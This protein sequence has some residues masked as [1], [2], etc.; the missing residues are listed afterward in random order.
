[1]KATL[2]HLQ[3]PELG[4]LGLDASRLLCSGQLRSLHEQFGYALAF[5]RDPISALESDVAAVLSELGAG[6]FGDPNEATYKVRHFKPGETGLT[7][8]VECL[9]PT[10]NGKQVLV[11]LVLTQKGAERFLTLEQVSS[12]T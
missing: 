10:N 11:E 9:V 2:S 6:S 1:M 7:S 5:D 3:D 4:Q 8:L 12:A